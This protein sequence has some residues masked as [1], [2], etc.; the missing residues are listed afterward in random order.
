MV[1]QRARI[2]DR[3]RPG[4]MLREATEAYERI[5]MLRRLEL[6]HTLLTRVGH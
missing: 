2:A 1:L 4:M 5:G 3:K 6:T